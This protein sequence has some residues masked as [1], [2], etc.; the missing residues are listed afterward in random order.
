MIGAAKMA[1][2]EGRTDR[3]GIFMADEQSRGKGGRNKEVSL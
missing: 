2:I 3:D 1:V